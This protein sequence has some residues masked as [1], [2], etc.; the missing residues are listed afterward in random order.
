MAGVAH[1]KT[2]RWKLSWECWRL[3]LA[4]CQERAGWNSEGNVNFCFDKKATKKKKEE[5]GNKKGW[6]TGHKK[7]NPWKKGLWQG[8]GWATPWFRW[9]FGVSCDSIS[10]FHLSFFSLYSAFIFVSKVLR[11]VSWPWDKGSFYTFSTNTPSCLVST[12][13]IYVQLK[14]CYNSPA[15][16]PWSASS[17]C[18]CSSWASCP[19]P[20]GAS[21]ASSPIPDKQQKVS[22]LWPR[23]EISQAVFKAYK[24]ACY[25]TANFHANVFLL[26]WNNIHGHQATI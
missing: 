7:S 17:Q 15:R 10:L 6:G 4:L 24:H 20:P 12:C 22:L 19:T 11:S 16:P 21:T 13:E 2:S 1:W 25:R 18:W 23:T 14:R 3:L 5:E 8:R 9:L 26:N